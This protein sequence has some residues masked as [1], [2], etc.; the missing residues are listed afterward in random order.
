VAEDYEAALRKVRPAVETAASSSGTG[1][2]DYVC[3]LYALAALSGRGRLGRAL[4][5]SL[6][7]EPETEVD[8]P[9]CG[10]CLLGQFTGTGLAFRA[11][12]C[13]LKTLSEDALVQPR[14]PDG[15]EAD[16]FDRMAGVCRAAGQNQLVQQL[17]LLH[18]TV[19]CP[20]CG[21]EMN[22]MQEI[23]RSQR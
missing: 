19:A 13:R 1:R 22:V 17:S 3:V 16:D 5:F 14:R 7:D 15:G 20:G 8:C 10:A 12:D 4:Y 18:G 6:A 21:A 11:V 23:L 9:A 2:E